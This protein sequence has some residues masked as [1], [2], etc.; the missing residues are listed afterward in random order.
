[1]KMGKRFEL[2]GRPC[3]ACGRGVLRAFQEKAFPGVFVNAYRCTHCSD[4]AYSEDVMRRLQ[5]LEMQGAE[6]RTLLKVGDSIA[7]AIP[8]RIVRELGLKQKE[9]VLVKKEGRNIL[10]QPLAA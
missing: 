9:K 4:V 1:M 6:Q 2:A 7:V 5:A 10:V 8:A 3:P